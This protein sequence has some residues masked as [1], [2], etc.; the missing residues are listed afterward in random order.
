MP[1][2][3]NTYSFPAPLSCHSILTVSN[4]TRQLLY[5]SAS[6]WVHKSL[7][8]NKCASCSRTNHIIRLKSRS[9]FKQYRH[10]VQSPQSC[11]H[12]PLTLCSHLHP[13]PLEEFP[14]GK[15]N[16]TSSQVLKYMAG[17]WHLPLSSEWKVEIY[18]GAWQRF[19]CFV[20]IIWFLSY[21]TWKPHLAP[22]KHK[23]KQKGQ[24]HMS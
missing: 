4:C 21:V 6:P 19:S 13:H 9:K 10:Q 17:L 7:Q 5:F 8:N 2:I 16:G 20:Q 3:V 15:K 14:G 24:R 22:Q 11:Q 23:G 12:T 18:Q 1:R